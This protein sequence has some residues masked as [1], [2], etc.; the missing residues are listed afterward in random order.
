VSDPV[1]VLFT[2]PPGTGKSTLADAIGRELPAP[3]FAW[4]WCMAPLRQVK[5]VFDAVMALEPVERW[6]LGY[7]L[8]EQMVEKQLRNEQPALVDCVARID[9]DRRFAAAA[10]RH[11]VPFFVVECTCA[12]VLLHRRRVEGRTRAI[13]GWYELEWSEV[14]RAR[15]TYQALTCAKLVVDAAD[16]L[17]ANLGRVRRHLGIG[18]DATKRTGSTT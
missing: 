9:A 18:K 7:A 2:G 10:A 16:P 6:S 3:V 4:D 17:E 14:Q 13:P 15:D 5:P 8:L 1:V 12:D 11:D